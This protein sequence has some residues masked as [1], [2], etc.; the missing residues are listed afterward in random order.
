MKTGWKTYKYEIIKCAKQNS[1]Y[2]FFNFNNNFIQEKRLGKR[3][4]SY[5]AHTVYKFKNCIK[6]IRLSP[7][8]AVARLTFQVHD[9]CMIELSSVNFQISTD[10]MWCTFIIL[11]FE[12]GD[13]Y[14][15]PRG[16]CSYLWKK[17]RNIYA[18]CSFFIQSIFADRN[19]CFQQMF[20]FYNSMKISNA[21]IK[22]WKDI[23]HSYFVKFW[24]LENCQIDH[25]LD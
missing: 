8:K 16:F 23:F 24:G 19:I 21:W 9:F 11:T 18:R 7:I 20:Y 3:Q 5:N 2:F 25:Y 10:F 1:S 13:E 4:S 14:L 17:K 12:A 22:I 15:C 6:T